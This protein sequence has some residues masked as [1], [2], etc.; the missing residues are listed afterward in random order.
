MNGRIAAH[1][2][3]KA[4]RQQAI[5]EI[6]RLV[7][8]FNDWEDAVMAPQYMTQLSAIA[9]EV[10]AAAC[11]L[12]KK[13]GPLDPDPVRIADVYGKCV[14][15][16]K[17]I[18]WL[19]RVYHYYRDKFD[20]RSDP[21]YG[22]TLKA[23]DE[24]IWSCFRAFFAEPL[25]VRVPEPVPLPY[26]DAEYSPIALRRTDTGVLGAKS[27]RQDVETAFRTLPV[28][29]LKLPIG[30]LRNPWIL[31][32]IGHEAGHFV[33]PLIDGN[34]FIQKFRTTLEKAG[35]GSWGPWAIEIFC[36]WY[37]I[38]TTG[39][40][41]IWAFAQFEVGD[42]AYMTKRRGVYPA[43]LVRLQ[44]LAALADR[45]GLDGGAMMRS[46]AIEEPAP[47]QYPDYDADKAAIEAVAEAIVQLPE[48]KELLGK[49]NFTAAD[50]A[51]GAG[52]A[53]QWANHLRGDGAKPVS[54]QLRSARMVA[55]G[56][57]EAWNGLVFTVPEPPAEDVL[58]E[59][60]QGVRQA[61]IGAAVPGVRSSSAA[62][63]CADKKPGE[64][65]ADFLSKAAEEDADTEE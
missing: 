65:L 24:V 9:S 42:M 34:A 60:R 41:M 51:A 47:G 21:R 16:E 32:L 27:E 53:P 25:E 48:C 22:D 57:A 40:W 49:V 43:P 30:L 14:K 15:I 38:V 35:G 31:T 56:A 46:L 10:R 54:R 58:D 8:D 18:T 17:Q 19:W 36:D 4:R 23:A 12:K 64:A 13:I 26:I 50:F 7:A 62:I 33:L 5:A 61:A 6:E 45:H 20:Q 37:G 3:G 29:L 59:L 63:I 1:L 39:P 52:I 44:L 55:A 28:P 11:I 2:S